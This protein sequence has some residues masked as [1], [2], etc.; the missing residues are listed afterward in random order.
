MTELP[1]D[2]PFSFRE[3]SDLVS[4]TLLQIEHAL[5]LLAQRLAWNKQ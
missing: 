1:Q 5:A 2:H 3:L 4:G